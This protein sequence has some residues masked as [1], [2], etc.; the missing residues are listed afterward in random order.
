MPLYDFGQ[1]IKERD[2]K[3]AV[4]DGKPFTLKDA[5]E[6]SLLAEYSPDGRP[7][8]P[9]IRN[10]RFKL[11]RKLTRAEKP[12]IEV[13]VEEVNTL[14]DAAA[15]FQTLTY[16][17]LLELLDGPGYTPPPPMP[18]PKPI[19]AAVSDAIGTSAAA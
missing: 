12:I 15:A 17:Q 10:A 6:E 2:G 3:D 4:K 13:T 9:S 7:P 19:A 14:K 16:G 11:W 8:Q 5:F 1:S 18:G